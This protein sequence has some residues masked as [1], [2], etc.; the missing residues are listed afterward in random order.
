VPVLL[1][2]LR[3]ALDTAVGFTSGF[4]AFLVYYVETFIVD[5][6]AILLFFRPPDDRY[7]FLSLLG[8][9]VFANVTFMVQGRGVRAEAWERLRQVAACWGLTLLLVLGVLFLLKS[10]QEFSRGLILCWAVIGLPF[11]YVGR[12]LE[13]RLTDRLTAAG[14]TRRWIAVVG[15]NAQADRL[16]RRF[17]LPDL[18]GSYGTAGVYDDALAWEE[19]VDGLVPVS[20]S[21]HDLKQLCRRERLDAIVIAVSG[22]E[23]GRIKGLADRLRELSTDLLLGP[24]I[25]QIELH[26]HADVRFGPLP[27]ASLARVPMQDWWELAKWLEDMA[28]SLLALAVLAPLLLVLAIAI[29][30]DSPASASTIGNS[31]S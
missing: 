6:V 16:L 27:A 3:L 13:R 10:G 7:L 21:V 31:W 2:L 8:G 20:G 19:G 17:A 4:V 9:L 1:D 5:P 30:I 12:T 26:T 22:D 25:A 28:V 24:D 14:V 18:A 15:A 11:L 23:A 29:K